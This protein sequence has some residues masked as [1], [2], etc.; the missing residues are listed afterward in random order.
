MFL[1]IFVFYFSVAVYVSKQMK[2]K[3]KENYGIAIK[4]EAAC[5]AIMLTGMVCSLCS[6]QYP[7]GS[8]IVIVA[9]FIL[10]S[11]LAFYSEKTI[12]A[13]YKEEPITKGENR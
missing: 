7:I 3:F 10:L 9:V 1:A 6:E 4:L 11:L 8:G 2:N 13:S 12:K 5:P